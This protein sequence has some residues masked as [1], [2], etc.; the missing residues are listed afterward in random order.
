MSDCLVEKE[1]ASAG[2]GGLLESKN[3]VLG[4]LVGQ[5]DHKSNL[6]KTDLPLHGWPSVLPSPDMKRDPAASHCFR[7]NCLAMNDLVAR[8]CSA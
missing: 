7:R 8:L 6:F 3:G 5:S 1:T 4:D 2:T